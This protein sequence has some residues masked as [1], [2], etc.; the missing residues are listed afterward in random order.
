VSKS[1]VGQGM[2]SGDMV[3]FVTCGS[4]DEARAIAEKLISERLAACVNVL[5]GVES[6]YRWQGEVNWDSEFLLMIKTT[7]DYLAEVQKTVMTLHS[8]ELPEFIAVGIDAGSPD[9]L[10]WIRD[11]VG[12]AN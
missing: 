1:I 11:A 3:A 4:H 10:E 6:C 7:A 8:Y 12:K 9:Y 5:A 2:A